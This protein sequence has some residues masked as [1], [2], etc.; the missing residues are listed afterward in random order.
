[1]ITYRSAVEFQ[2]R[3]GR[4]ADRG[5]RFAFDVEGYL[6]HQGRKLVDRFDAASYV[7]LTEIMDGHDVGDIGQ[8]A[9]ATAARVGELVGVGIDTDILYDAREVLDWVN[10][11]RLGGA[12]ATYRE[13]ETPYG[14][15]AFLIEWDQLTAILR[16]PEGL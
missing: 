2:Q 10:A 9:W 7:A 13:I 8:A 3:F 12:R 15:D 11:Y 5:E 4:R 14:H 1:M 16:D 6:R